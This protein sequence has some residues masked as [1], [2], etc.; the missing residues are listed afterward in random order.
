MAV[1]HVLISVADPGFPIVGGANSRGGAP[2][3]YLTNFSRKVHENKEN[4]ARGG[5]HTSLAI[6]RSA[7]EYFI[8]FSLSGGP[9]TCPNSECKNFTVCS[10]TKMLPICIVKEKYYS[11]LIVCKPLRFGSF[12]FIEMRLCNIDLSVAHCYHCNCHCCHHC[13]F[14]WVQLWR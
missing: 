9:P 11:G 2:T 7:T 6:P 1:S 10:P 4:L 13:L 5:E 14:F 3:Y 12:C 8:Q